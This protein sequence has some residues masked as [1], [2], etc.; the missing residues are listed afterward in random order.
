MRSTRLCTRSSE[1]YG[2]WWMSLT[3]AMR[4]PS[5]TGGTS[6]DAKVTYG[7]GCFVLVNVGGSHGAPPYGLLRTAAASLLSSQRDFG[8]AMA[9][10]GLAWVVDGLIRFI[11][12]HEIQVTRERVWRRR[13][14]SG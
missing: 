9:V 2:P 6:G 4:R 14:D 3:K 1:K 12:D 7:T 13:D 5:K 11:H 10:V 8:I